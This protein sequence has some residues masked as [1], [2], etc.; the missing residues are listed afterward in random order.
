MRREH[1][2]NLRGGRLQVQDCAGRHPLVG[3]ND[4]APPSR[5]QEALTDVLDDH[6]G[7]MREQDRVVVVPRAK[8]GIEPVVLPVSAENLVLALVQA[9]V[10]HEQTLWLARHQPPPHQHAHLVVFERVG[11]VRVPD[12]RSELRRN[13][14]GSW[15]VRPYR[16]VPVFTVALLHLCDAAR[17]DGVDTADH[18]ADLPGDLEKYRLAHSRI[19]FCAGA[20]TERFKSFITFI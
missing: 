18:V 5:Q 8:Q 12:V 2:P 1:G 14:L 6:A 3:L 16:D 15:D 20:S 17:Q 9:R 19:C 7:A 13:A 4:G 10:I 11:E